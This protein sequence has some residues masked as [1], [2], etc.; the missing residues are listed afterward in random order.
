[1][2]SQALH[3]SVNQLADAAEAAGPDLL[4]AEVPAKPLDQIRSG[5]TRGVKCS[6]KPEWS[7]SQRS[8]LVRG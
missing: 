3:D 2:M 7:A 1:M 4:L 8:V 5:G 6:S